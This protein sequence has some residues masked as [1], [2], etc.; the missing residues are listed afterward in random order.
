[1]RRPIPSIPNSLMNLSPADALIDAELAGVLP[2]ADL[3]DL[4]GKRLFITGG[5]GFYGF[6][7]LSALRLLNERGTAITATVLSR[8]PQQFLTR[9]PRFRAQRW[10]QWLTG[11]IADYPFPEQRFDIFIHAATDTRPAA[12]QAQ[13]SLL[14][15]IVGG[16][17][18]VI[19]HAIHAGTRR[20]VLCSSGAVYGDIPPHLAPIAEASLT[21]QAPP[22]SNNAYAEGKRTMEAM[23][24][25]AMAE[26]GL[27]PVIA[28]GFAFI[29]PGLP[30]H[31]HFAIG[32][33]IADALAGR[34]IEIRSNGQALRSYLHGADLAV[35][36]LVMALRG[37]AGRIYNLG[38]DQALTLAQLARI[39]CDVLAPNLH[40][41][42]GDEAVRQRLHY[43]P[44]IERA[45]SELAL[46]PWTPIDRAI[47]ATGAWHRLAAAG[48]Q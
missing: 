20:I 29:G 9:H 40:V 17:R 37:D 44:N 14:D 1:M 45:R 31:E 46:A 32:N 33:F 5:T 4:A 39:V 15:T 16:S 47:S 34:N 28:R 2:H 6:W 42:L 26:H 36:L 21:L 43:V 13:L 11:D 35:W 27:S 19:Q 24:I 25:A 18:R 12:Q 48:R 38:S 41:R 10:L 30:L 22:D 3:T 8:N 7:L 23:A